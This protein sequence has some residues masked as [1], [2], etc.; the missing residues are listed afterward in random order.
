MTMTNASPATMTPVEI[1]TFLAANWGEQQKLALRLHG[2]KRNLAGSPADGPVWVQNNRVA[3]EARIEA[4]TADLEAL[5]AEARP[6]EVEYASRPWNRYFLVANDNGHVHRGMNCSTC[7]V[8]TEYRW[9][10]DLADCDEDAMIEEWGERACTVCFP[11]APVNPFYSRPA[12]IDREAQAARQAEAA[13][14]NA[15]KAAKGIVD[16]DGS[17]LRSEY[18]V[19]KTKVAARNELSGAIKSLAWY[20]PGH[21]T[22]F[23]G[24]ARKMAAALR[25]N[26]PEIDV[27]KVIANAIKAATKDGA[28]YAGQVPTL[29]AGEA[30]AE[31][32]E[33]GLDV[34]LEA[35]LKALDGVTVTRRDIVLHGQKYGEALD[36]TFAMPADEAAVLVTNASFDEPDSGLS[37]LL[38]ELARRL[39]AQAR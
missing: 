2:E 36:V 5:K 20:G 3:I 28:T 31:T 29:L 25:A 22:D 9:L 12:R 16:V 32:I 24:I 8:T 37:T 15:D 26:A 23:A 7:F 6:Y 17:P 14:R 10:I 30:P 33:D 13:K 1:D 35:P 18:G 4:L 11:S 19:I 21:P 39:R 34:R 27:D 38:L